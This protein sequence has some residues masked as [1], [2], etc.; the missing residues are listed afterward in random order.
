[1]P[2]S[3]WSALRGVNSSF[4]KKKLRMAWRDRHLVTSSIISIMVSVH[5]QNF[6]VKQYMKCCVTK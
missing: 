2:L 1:M 5:L 4:F 3:D 6:N